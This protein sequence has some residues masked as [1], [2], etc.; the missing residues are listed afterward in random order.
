MG[1]I[2]KATGMAGV[3][4][5]LQDFFRFMPLLKKP[6]HCLSSVYGIFFL[7]RVGLSNMLDSEL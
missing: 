5:S 7:N 6:F 2:E 3:F 1:N 4:A